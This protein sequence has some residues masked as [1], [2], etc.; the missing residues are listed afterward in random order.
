MPTLP[1][2][3][4]A[5]LDLRWGVSGIRLIDTVTDRTLRLEGVDDRR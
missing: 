5:Q 3:R 2:L 1:S 4:R